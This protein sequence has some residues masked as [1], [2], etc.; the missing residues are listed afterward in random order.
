MNT[1]RRHSSAS[2]ESPAGGEQRGDSGASQGARARELRAQ[3]GRIAGESVSPDSARFN[4]EN[5]QYEAQ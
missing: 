1:R 2:Y 3:G 5:R 4:R